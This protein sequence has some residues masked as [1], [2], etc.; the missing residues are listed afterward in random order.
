MDS[1]AARACGAKVSGGINE[2]ACVGMRMMR[3]KDA[4]NCMQEGYFEE[5]EVREGHVREKKSFRK[6]QDD[7]THLHQLLLKLPLFVLHRY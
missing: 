1:S 7:G 2:Q 4:E 6:T 3:K 5:K